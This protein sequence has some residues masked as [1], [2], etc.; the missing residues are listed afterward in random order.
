MAYVS[1]NYPLYYD[2]INDVNDKIRMVL[3][4]IMWLILQK[5]LCFNDIEI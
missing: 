2:A 5:N 1:E 4:Q 3:P